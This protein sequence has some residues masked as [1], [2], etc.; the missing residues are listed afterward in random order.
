MQASIDL[1]KEARKYVRDM[2]IT[3]SNKKREGISQKKKKTGSQ[4]GWNRED[5]RLDAAW[6][7]HYLH[8]I[9][10]EDNLKKNPEPVLRKAAG[11]INDPDCR[12]GNCLEQAAIAY[13]YLV[14]KGVQPVWLLSLKEP[15]DHVF[16]GLGEIKEVISL[17]R[18]G[19]DAFVCDPWA[20]IACRFQEYKTDW[21]AKMTKWAKDGKTLDTGPQKKESDPLGFIDPRRIEWALAITTHEIEVLLRHPA[22]S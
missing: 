5:Q 3:A 20:N 15:G 21:L 9:Y 7:L 8:Q 18:W 22:K 2:N 19:S 12:W 6:K 13:F 1:A 10:R 11:L 16:V 17:E 4:T 14:D